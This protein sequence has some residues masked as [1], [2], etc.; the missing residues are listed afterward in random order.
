MSLYDKIGKERD[1]MK[2]EEK[3]VFFKVGT[4]GWCLKDFEVGSEKH[5]KNVCLGIE[6]IWKMNALEFGRKVTWKIYALEY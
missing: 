6:S 4:E 2:F 3:N 5:L 1:R